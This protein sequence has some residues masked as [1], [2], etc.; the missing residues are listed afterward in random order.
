MLKQI[1][2]VILYVADMDAQ[3]RFYRDV[4][5]L[6]IAFPADLEDYSQEFWVV[7]DTG[8]CKLALHGGGSKEFGKDAPKFVFDSD[9]V[10]STRN[11]LI[12]QA[13]QVGD[14]REPAPGVMVFDGVDPEG[15]YFSVEHRSEHR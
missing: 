15:N 5:Q 1:S 10:N 4:M 11:Y 8:V 9:D 14:V 12:D 6:P 3:V 13:V 2:E 7:F